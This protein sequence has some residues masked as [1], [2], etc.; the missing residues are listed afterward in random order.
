MLALVNTLSMP[1]LSNGGLSRQIELG[2]LTIT[3]KELT[4][5][6]IRRGIDEQINPL[7]GDEPMDALLELT[8]IGNMTL[9]DILRMTDLGHQQLE[10]LKPSELLAVAEVCEQVNVPFFK[11]AKLIKQGNSTA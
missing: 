6:E 1:M 11:L 9:G 7:Q 2:G 8:P 4:V 3:V 5:M 10:A